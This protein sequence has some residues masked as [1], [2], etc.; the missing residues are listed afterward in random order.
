M[1]K[2]HLIQRLKKPHGS[3]DT[4]LEIFNFGGGFKNGGLSDEAM[5]LIRGI[6]SFDYMGA[7]EYEFGAVPEAFQKIGKNVKHMTTATM[8]VK[9]KNGDVPVYIIAHEEWIPD[10]KVLINLFATD[11]YGKQTPHIKRGVHLETR[12]NKP[13]EYNQDQ[14]GW[15]ELDNGFFFFIDEKMFRDTARLVGVE[16]KS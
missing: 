2:S 12:I 7:A 9:G 16:V 3:K 5:D 13:T 11:P 10:I 15:F 4:V 8:T 1:K 6:F 14:V